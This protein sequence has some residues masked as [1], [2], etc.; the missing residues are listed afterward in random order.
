MGELR[1]CFTWLMLIQ[2]LRCRI[3]HP[4]VHD[5]LA[6]LVRKNIQTKFVLPRSSPD[7]FWSSENR[8]LR[9]GESVHKALERGSSIKLQVSVRRAPCEQRSQPKILYLRVS[10]H[11]GFRIIC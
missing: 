3:F 9:N 8:R 6:S 2:K 11:D 1:T 7:H 5:G 10:L 4:I